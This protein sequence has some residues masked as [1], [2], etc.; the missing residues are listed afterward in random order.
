MLLKKNKIK[1]KYLENK[2]LKLNFGLQYSYFYSIL[3]FLLPLKNENIRKMSLC[4]KLFRKFILL[5]IPMIPLDDSLER[6]DRLFNDY[7][8]ELVETGEQPAYFY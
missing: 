5:I 1:N 6:F 4:D 8:F 7:L 2:C 3:R